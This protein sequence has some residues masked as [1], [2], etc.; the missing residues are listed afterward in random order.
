MLTETKT[1]FVVNT[2][3]CRAKKQ[4]KSGK[5]KWKEPSYAG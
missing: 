4:G 2:V 3:D 5:W 1:R